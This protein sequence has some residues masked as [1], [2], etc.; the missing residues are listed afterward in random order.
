MEWQTKM[1]KI[2]II[3]AETGV[4]VLRD[5]TVEE[6]ADLEASKIIAETNEQ[7]HAN[8]KNALLKKLGITAD[9][10]KLLLS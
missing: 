9:E 5:M 7:E 8:A 6:L 3:N 2:L 1:S 10:A 4:E